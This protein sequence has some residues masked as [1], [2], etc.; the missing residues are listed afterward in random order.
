MGSSQFMGPRGASAGD[1]ELPV[2]SAIPVAY[3]LY[4]NKAEFDTVCVFYVINNWGPKRTDQ[5]HGQHEGRLETRGR[6]KGSCER[7]PGQGHAGLWSDQE[8]RQRLVYEA[9]QST[10]PIAS[11]SPSVTSSGCPASGSSPSLRVR[12]A[13]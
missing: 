7:I 9:L 6:R 12:R 1:L 10:P 11:H 4:S 8:P 3:F 5:G 13:D 2:P